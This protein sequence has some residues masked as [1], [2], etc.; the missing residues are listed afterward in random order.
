MMRKGRIVFT[1]LMA[2]LA[3]VVPVSAQAV[4]PTGNP[5]APAGEVEV[6]GGSPKNPEAITPIPPPATPA[7][8]KCS[9][10][11]T[12]VSNKGTITQP[13]GKKAK[14]RG[15]GASNNSTDTAP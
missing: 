1:A 5:G 14:L 7:T 12:Q 3:L 2:V 15:H 6:Y 4:A 10:G 8:G 11:D 13:R 9:A